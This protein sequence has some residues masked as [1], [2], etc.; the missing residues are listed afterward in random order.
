M[1]NAQ[2]VEPQVMSFATP[3]ELGAWLAQNH[4]LEYVGLYLSA[5]ALLT[6]AGLLLT[7]ETKDA[8]L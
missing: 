4:G 3:E 7:R 6:L 1:K 2:K 8:A 5:A